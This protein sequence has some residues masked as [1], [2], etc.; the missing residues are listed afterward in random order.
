MKQYRKK[1]LIILG[2]F[3]LLVVVSGAY[4]LYRYLT[5]DRYKVRTPEVEPASY[6]FLANRQ[7]LVISWKYVNH[8]NEQEANEEPLEYT[9]AIYGKRYLS[10]DSKR[11]IYKWDDNRFDVKNLSWG[12]YWKIQVYD[13]S[14]DDLPRKE[15]DLLKAVA[16]YDS[17]YFPV[18]STYINFVTYNDQEYRKVV[19]QKTGGHDRKEVLFNMETGKLEDVPKELGVALENRY[20]YLFNR[21]TSLKN[22]YYNDD[23]IDNTTCL[24]L[25]QSVIEQSSDWLLREKYPKAYDLM[26]KEKG[27]LYFLT[28]ETDVKLLSDIFSLLIPKDRDLFDNLTVYG[29]VTRDGKDHVVHSYEEFINVL[30]PK[31]EL[32]NVR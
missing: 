10:T 11:L 4:P 14:Q 7:G 2:L 31:E 3:S 9:S 20:T 29:E 21:Y 15:Y 30:K 28:N 16:D 18:S 13:T 32:S 22:Y 25:S 1:I 26:S 19:L 5:H 6:E 17:S 24:N 23:F 8:S 27:S 12:E